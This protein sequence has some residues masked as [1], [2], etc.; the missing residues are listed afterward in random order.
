MSKPLHK[1]KVLVINVLGGLMLTAETQLHL[2]Q[3]YVE[4]NVYAYLAFAAVL[5]NTVLRFYTTQPLG[6]VTAEVSHE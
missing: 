2:I 4:G 6:S 3:P 1:S 5:I